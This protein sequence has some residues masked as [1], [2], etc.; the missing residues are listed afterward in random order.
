ML[1]YYLFVDIKIKVK[2]IHYADTTWVYFQ[3]GNE[4]M[5]EMS[6]MRDGIEK[7]LDYLKNKKESK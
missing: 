7:A 4:T 5:E 1:T 6:S 2:I 3:N